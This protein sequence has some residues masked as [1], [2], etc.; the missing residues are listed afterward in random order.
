MARITVRLDDELVSWAR[1]EAAYR[2]MTLPEYVGELIRERRDYLRA[3]ERFMS[4]APVMLRAPGE[5]LPKREDLYD[6]PRRWRRDA[7]SSFAASPPSDR[8]A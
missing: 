6:R 5:P 1:R 7:D 8:G 2:K 4:K 3:M